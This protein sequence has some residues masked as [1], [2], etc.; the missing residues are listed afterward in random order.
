MKNKKVEAENILKSLVHEIRK[1]SYKITSYEELEINFKILR[2]IIEKLENIDNSILV[3]TEFIVKKSIDYML[4]NSYVEES[5]NMLK[6]IIEL[7]SKLKH[8]NYIYNIVEHFS[9]KVANAKLLKD[10]YDSISRCIGREL[11]DFDIEERI[12]NIQSIYFFEIYNSAVLDIMIKEYI[13]EGIFMIYTPRE[14]DSSNKNYQEKYIIKRTVLYRILKFLI[15]KNDKKTFHNLIEKIYEYNWKWIDYLNYDEK[16]KAYEIIVVINI[17]L[18]YIAIG[19]DDC[20]QTYKQQVEGF[21]GYE[22][23]T[24]NLSKTTNSKSNISSLVKRIGIKKMWGIYGRA[25]EQV[26]N[27]RWEYFLNDEVKIMIRNYMVDEFFL[28][29]T[30]CSKDRLEYKNIL[31][32]EF[33]ITNYEMIL[34]YFDDKGHLKSEI[35]EKLKKFLDIYNYRIDN[36]DDLVKMVYNITK[37][38]YAEKLK[39]KK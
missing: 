34:S 4:E 17:F 7:E 18:Y 12:E 25:K 30:I 15:E 23:K 29:Y 5:K 22:I 16:N 6:D 20:S 13:I 35:Y 21:I 1:S 11:L 26:Y 19:S 9:R 28:F 32:T 37:D 39:G 27:N 3:D 8:S 38:K 14:S 33:E 24:D 2:E 10:E 31:D 36:L